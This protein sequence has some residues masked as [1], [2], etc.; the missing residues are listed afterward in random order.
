[1]H[2]EAVVVVADA[3]EIVLGCC[4]SLERDEV[5][6]GID[7]AKLRK[8]SLRGE[9]LGKEIIRLGP[10]HFRVLIIPAEFHIVCSELP[11][12]VGSNGNIFLVEGKRVVARPKGN[13]AEVAEQVA[14]VVSVK[15]VEKIVGNA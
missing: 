7:W 15:A 12:N 6:S 4:A 8:V 2:K 14:T 10:I 9:E 3:H 5:H 11:G 13:L 1:M